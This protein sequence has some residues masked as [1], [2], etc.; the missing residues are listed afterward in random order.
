[1]RMQM[2]KNLLVLMTSVLFSSIYQNGDSALFSDLST[3]KFLETPSV[4]FI[5]EHVI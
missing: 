5:Q 4:V 1:M 2:F 3:H